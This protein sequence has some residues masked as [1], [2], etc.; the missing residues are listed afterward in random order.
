MN[1]KTIV[2][3]IGT[4]PEA[5]K[6][7][8]VVLRL[9][10]DA[11]LRSLVV[12]TGQHRALV[13]QVLADF[14]IKP[15]IDLDLMRPGQGLAGLTASLV[16]TLDDRLAALGPIDLALVQGDTTTAFSAALAAFYRRVPVGHVEAGLRT[17]DLSAPW[18]EEANRQLIARLASLHFAPTDGARANLVREGIDPASIEVTGNTGIDALLLAVE[19]IE[20]V[21]MKMGHNRPHV[22]ITCHRRESFGA[23]MRSIC[24]AVAD[25]AAR[26]PGVRFVFPVHPN[27]EVVATVSAVLGNPDDPRLKAGN[28]ER[29]G[30]LPYHAFVA[31]MA[32]STLI[33]TDSG[34]A[35]EEAPSLGKPVLVLR[36]A[37]ERPEGVAAGAVRV[38]G[39]D[40][41]RVVA[42][43]SRLLDDPE[44]ASAMARVRNPYGDGRA[45]ERIVA[46]CRRF[47]GLGP[48]RSGDGDT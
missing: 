5:I 27:P 32:S 38:V 4:R 42:E 1:R 16:E 24:E 36:D 22:L 3:V 40:R 29:I 2:S 28:V 17:H 34:G 45:A 25:L 9:R 23:P 39:T 41:G 30:P 21:N 37:T 44:A 35:Q 10:R 33:L 48:S 47:L 18:P 43:V 7:A 12:V 26:H 14:A 11:D 8:P 13:D 31:A 15:D 19:T 6:M 20:T 46:L